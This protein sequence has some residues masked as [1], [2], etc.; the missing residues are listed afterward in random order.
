MKRFIVI[1]SSMLTTTPVKKNHSK[2]VITAT[3]IGI[4]MIAVYLL[5]PS[6][7]TAQ[8]QEQKEWLLRFSQEQKVKWQTERTIAE[9]TAKKFNMPI[10]KTLA[11]GRT[12]ELQRFENGMPKYFIT[13]NLNAARTLS[14]DDVWPGGSGGFSLSG[15]NETL[16]EWDAGRVRI[17]HQEFNGRATQVDGSPTNHYHSTHVA[18]TMIAAGVDPNAKGMS[19]QG[20]LRAYDWNSDLSE[21]ATAAAAGLKVSNHSYGYIT[22]WYYD[23]FGDGRWAWFGDPAISDTEDYYYG[24]YDSGAQDMDDIAR[25]APDYLIVRSAGNDRGYGPSSQPVTHWVY[26]GGWVLQSTVRQLDGGSDGYDCIYHDALAKN[27]LTVGAVDDIPAGWT[28]SSDVNMSSFSS[29]G[30]ADDGRIKPDIVANGISLYSTLETSNSAY[31]S[32]SG[33]SMASP[34]AAGSVGLLLNN[35]KNIA[36]NL[37]YRSATIKGLILHTADEAGS[38]PGPDYKFGWGLMNTLKAVQVMRADSVAGGNFNLREST[39]NQGDTIEFQ[40]RSNGTQ[41]LRATICWTDP[42][43]T[44]LAAQLNPTTPMLVNDLDLRVISPSSTTYLPWVLDPANPAAAATTGDNT[45]DNVE[46]VYI[47]LPASGLYTVRI[48]HKGTLSGGQQA[49]SVVVTGIVQGDVGTVGILAPVGLIDSTASIVP[50][51]SVYNYGS[52]LIDSFPVIFKILRPFPPMTW[53]DTQMVHNLG[54]GTGTSVAFDPW[55]VGARGI[56]NTSCSTALVGDMDSTNDRQDSSFTIAAHDVAVMGIDVPTGMVQLDSA[57]T[58][59]A[60]IRNYGSGSDSFNVFLRIGTSY[61]DTFFLRVVVGF[62]YMISF[63]TWTAAPT[64]TFEVRCS[65]DLASDLITFNDT[66]SDSVTVYDNDAGVVSILKPV[67]NVDSTATIVPRCSVYNYSSQPATFQVKFSITGPV[68]YNNTQ[69]VTNLAAGSGITVP[70][71]P[72]TVGPTGN[73]TARCS[74][75]LSPDTNALNDTLSASFNIQVHDVGTTEILGPKGLVVLNS[76]IPPKA[77]FQNFGSQT[78][79]FDVSLVVLTPVPSSWT[80]S[81]TLTAGQVDTVS[82]APNW[83][84]TPVGTYPVRCSTSLANDSIASNNLKFDSVIVSDAD[85]GVLSIFAPSGTL[86][87]TSTIVPQCSVYNYGSTPATFP[88]TFRISG[89]PPYSNTQTVIALPPNSGIAVPFAPWTVGPRGVYT[90]RC[91]TEL[92]PDISRTNDTLSASFTIIVHDVGTTQILAPKGLVVINSL[93]QPQAVIRNYGTQIETFDVSLVVL[94]PVPSSWTLSRTLTA[95]Q[96]DTVSFAPNWLATPVGTHPVRCSTSL[97]NDSVPINNLKNDS[98]IVS[99]ADVGVTAIITPA[100]AID[101]TLTLTPQA[102]VFNYGSNPA[103][104]PVILRITGPATYADTQIV[105]LPAGLGQIVSFNPWTIGPRGTYTVRCTTALSYDTSAVNDTMSQQFEIIVHDVGTFEILAPKGVVPLNRSI[106]PQAIFRN[107]GTET[108]TFDVSLVV[109]TPVPSSWT[110]SRT[111]TAGQV[112]TVSFAPNWSATPVGTYPVRCSTALARDSVAVNNLLIDSV[113]ISDADVGVT[114][115]VYPTGAIDSTASLLPQATVFNYGSTDASF[116]VILRITGP[117]IYVDTQTVTNLP[118]NT[119]SNVSFAAW[120]IGPRGLYTVS[121]STAFNIDTAAVNDTMSSQFEII[122]HDVGTAQILA[123]TGV[124]PINSSITPQAIVRN[125][126]TET[127]TLI[128]AL[129]VLT[130]IPIT[131]TDT[132]PLDSGQ[133]DTVNFAPPWLATPVGTYPVRCSTALAGDLVVVNDTLSDSVQV[134][135]YDV[136]VNNI[137]APVGTVDSA[138]TP[139]VTPQAS[140]QNYAT[141]PVS[142]PA[143]FRISRGAYTWADTQTINLNAGQTSTITFNA[144]TVGSGGN[145]ATR[146]TTGLDGDVNQANNWSDS[147]FFVRVPGGDVGVTALILNPPGPNIDSGTTVSISARVLNFGTDVATFQVRTKIGSFYLDSLLTPLTL[148]PGDS[149]SVNFANWIALQ[150]GTRT[151]RCSTELAGDIYH[152][153]DRR[154]QNMSVIVRDV[155]TYQIVYPTGNIDSIGTPLTPQAIVENVGNLV[156]D[157][158]PVIFQIAGPAA[159]ADTKTVRNLSPSEQ[160]TVNFAP[161]PIGPIGAYT[162]ACSTAYIADMN[163]SNDRRTGQFWVQRCDIGVDSIVSPLGVVDSGSTAVVQAGITNFG[164]STKSF[165]AI[166]RIGSFYVDTVAV[167]LTSLNDSIISFN[168]WQAN[169]PGGSY[170][171]QCTTVIANDFNEANNQVNDSVFVGVKDVG[172]DSILSPTPVVSPGSIVPEAWVHN[173][174]TDSISFTTYFRIRNASG[175]VYFDSVPFNNLLPDSIFKPTFPIWNAINGTYIATCSLAVPNDMITANDTMSRV[176]VVTLLDAQ[177]RRIVYPGRRT[178]QGPIQPRIVVK[179]N[180]TVT[181]S[182]WSWFSITDTLTGT[183]VYFDSA[184]CSALLQGLERIIDFSV[185]TATFGNYSLKTWTGLVGDANPA[186]DTITALCRVDTILVPKWSQKRDMPLGPRNRYVQR[187]GTITYGGGNSLYAL[188][189]ANTN[190]FYSYDAAA[191][192]WGAKETIP[193]A[194]ERKKRISSGAAMCWDG[195]NDLFVIKG[196][197]TLEFWAYLIPFDTWIRLTDVKPGNRRIKTGSGLA[198]A[199][200]V[201]GDNVYCLKGS[202]T[203]EFYAYSLTNNT[204]SPRHIL[205]G[206]YRGKPM[207][208]G[209]AITYDPYSGKIY[210]VKGVENEFFAYDIVTDTW[211]M[212]A[213]MPLFGVSGSKRAKDGAS[214]AADGSGQ[215]YAFKGNNSQE[216]MIYHI[217]EGWWEQ[218]EPLPLGP[219]MRKVKQGGSLAYAPFNQKIYA[220]KGNRTRELWVFDPNAFIFAN[221]PTAPMSSNTN[222]VKSELAD[223]TQFKITPNPNP[224]RFTINYKL[225]KINSI[226]CCLY[227]VLGNLVLEQTTPA[228]NKSGTIKIDAKEIPTGIYIL[229]LQ[230]GNNQFIGKILIQK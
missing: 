117:A 120:T 86:D 126:G 50:R 73:Y 79:T 77:V 158:F 54:A 75:E 85:V 208:A 92:N 40:V 105:N 162:T 39:L 17:E 110:Q 146:C 128:V 35:R 15:A 71:A 52:T 121:C 106:T 20:I 222:E 190:E 67:G 165:L 55:P 201:L 149:A 66:L 14:T 132:V 27:I 82:F 83:L 26:S 203:F 42:A 129:S 153:N 185:W 88:V 138:T 109:L 229:R 154:T 102:S 63:R 225:S 145:Y 197:N 196:S 13:E 174:G 157:S 139:T 177:V 113:I 156:V 46:Q 214:L 159:Y 172:V 65:T 25:N 116:P 107:I 51:C 125:F 33:T 5:I 57:I 31:G 18:G 226:K 198:Y 199:S 10:R 187:G 143:I 219:N 169:Q 58:P 182:F 103:S 28:D 206:G 98:V 168:D 202:K 194:V 111:L 36:G 130:A 118:P 44:P 76:S 211:T 123:P 131:W 192:I 59:V 68:S 141:V 220:T 22:G 217:T 2:T 164:T 6:I 1:L 184:Y 23:Y 218:I 64:G 142:F 152:A 205:P 227:N 32:L 210:A 133:I 161:W 155:R 151:V 49:V 207:G 191:D 140:V 72:W 221:T 8:T 181:E 171:I 170:A 61:V 189:G 167:T 100:G 137:V 43:A 48:T 148:N 175:T 56:Y 45:R 119:A 81:R 213:A 114:A 166:F 12:I 78:E 224:G 96:I 112:D 30:F 115:I 215:I 38:F 127:D 29:W 16:G 89:S 21:M 93:I 178:L 24:F 34:N 41:P 70:F 91:S 228:T 147:V 204:W 195:T 179:N 90:A 37:P 3:L 186:N 80:L 11:D 193:Y 94:T 124:V 95:G 47:A 173:Y 60:R 19:Y 144:W 135:A 209:S 69:N 230:S 87:S 97:A 176:I 122:V 74:T 216:F 101:S 200:T 188:K 212:L 223:I 150:R 160:Y 53:S 9:S 62:E 108:E 136:G 99:D 134:V 7:M 4:V 84:A 104:F 180:S 163:N 183:L